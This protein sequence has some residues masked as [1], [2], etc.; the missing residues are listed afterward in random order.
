MSVLNTA[1][2]LLL[3]ASL[4][5][6]PNRIGIENEPNGTVLQI[7][8][9]LHFQTHF[10]NFDLIASFCDSIIAKTSM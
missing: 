6:S 9:L 7:K 8:Q 3:K 1:C 5:G 10:L 4:I 2:A